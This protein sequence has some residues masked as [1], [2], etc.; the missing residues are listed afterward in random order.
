[1]YFVQIKRNLAPSLSQLSKQRCSQVVKKRNVARISPTNTFFSSNSWW[2]F[3]FCLQ[4]N[5]VF[6]YSR[7]I[8]SLVLEFWV[9]SRRFVNRCQ[10]VLLPLL[11]WRH[12]LPA[13]LWALTLR[14]HII[15]SNRYCY[16]CWRIGSR[17]R[18]VYLSTAAQLSQLLLRVRRT[19]RTYHS[20]FDLLLITSPRKELPVC[21]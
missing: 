3:Y 4:V 19:T 2:I 14:P 21:I 10:S 8:V 13:S 1:M 12:I 20:C 5:L 15:G 9:M 11:L 17:L 7:Q 6:E 16:S 18:D